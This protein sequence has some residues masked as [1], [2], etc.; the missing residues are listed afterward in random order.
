MTEAAAVLRGRLPLRRGLPQGGSDGDT[1]HTLVPVRY[2][3]HLVPSRPPSRRTTAET[4]GRALVAH[5]VIAASF[6]VPLVF[7]PGLGSG[8][9]PVKALVLALATL[10]VL[11]G[12]VLDPA[13]PRHAVQLVRTSRMLQVGA[14]LLALGAL[15][16]L[17]SG[18][19]RDALIGGYPD[20]RGLLSLVAFSV[21][22]L[23]A[24]VLVAEEQPGEERFLRRVTRAAAVGLSVLTAVALA[25]KAGLGP[26]SM[27]LPGAVRAI[28]S[29]G[30]ASN[31]G[32]VCCLLIPLA[33]GGALSDSDRRWRLASLVAAGG[34]GVAI[35]WTLSRGAWL[36]MLVGVA[37][38]AACAAAWRADPSGAVGASKRETTPALVAP[39]RRAAFTAA[40]VL[41]VGLAVGAATMPGALPRAARI[42]D[43]GSETASWRL[44]TWRSTLVLIGDHPLLGVGPNGFE[45]AFP[46]YKAEGS[47]DGRLGYLPTE[48]AHNA[49]LDATAS[50][51]LL[52]LLAMAAL[53]GLAGVAVT[54]RLREPHPIPAA[55]LA[56]SLV[57]GV[58]ALMLH[59]VTLDSG[60][61]LALML[62]IAAAWSPAP[63]HTPALAERPVPRTSA[64]PAEQAARLSALTA[65]FAAAWAALTIGAVGLLIADAS[66]GAAAR[67]AAGGGDW[68]SLSARAESF[69]PWE[70]AMARSTG[71][72]A[73]VALRRD[74]DVDL[75]IEVG[76][77][78]YARASR[79]APR[80]PVLAA[81]S[82][83]FRLSAAAVLRDPRR[84]AAAREL[85]ERA[86]E[87]DP[88]S[89]LP[90][91]VLGRVAL[92]SGDADEAES[93]LERAVELS[94]ASR[95]GWHALSQAR[96]LLGNEAGSQEAARRAEM[97]AR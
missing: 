37:V 69:A 83:R 1:G 35:V 29:A 78:A 66:A 39:S 82:A 24:A 23:A 81:E 67:A 34:G 55:A 42:L 43:T 56:V 7:A 88:A 30:N 92:V 25:E 13:I 33:I 97:L 48:S 31:L 20:Y 11:V 68:R 96:E 6:V 54:R 3:S 14:G 41:V 40:V 8:F 21:V 5:G 44:A 49:L 84:V 85:V 90:L 89:G 59:Y 46:R 86:Q 87:L 12:A 62:G 2:W 16:S 26:A 58:T 64:P 63:S 36:G 72:A 51:G 27:R 79:L 70:P 80:D 77:A 28:S 32:V 47:D 74:A 18:Q 19:M 22:G 38:A 52:G 4:R 57:A 73:S 45:A 71:R 91:V 60:P 94:P 17:A 9:G 76:E 93:V 10:A 95:E 65:V 15:S 53:A 50:F 75:A 61:L